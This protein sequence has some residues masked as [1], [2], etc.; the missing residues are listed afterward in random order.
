MTKRLEEVFDFASFDEEAPAEIIE[1]ANEEDVSGQIV[2]INSQ[3]DKIDAALVGVTQL[4]SHDRDMDEIAKTAMDAY[5][6]LWDISQNIHDAQVS[7]VL[8]V[9]HN[10][11]KTAQDA[12]EAKNYRKLKMVELQIK[13]ARL[14]WEMTHKKTST[15]APAGS[16]G[17]YFDRN[18]LIGLLLNK[19]NDNSADK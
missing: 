10:M 1:T 2:D 16:N 7:K 11:L 6:D 15:D 4:D 3:S 18:E 5:R 19:D 17:V 8:E 14:D 9:A 13:K 12:K